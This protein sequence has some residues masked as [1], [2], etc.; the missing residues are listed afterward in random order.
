MNIKN[1][2]GLTDDIEDDLKEFLENQLQEGERRIV[3]K[4]TY[5]ED[6]DCHILH[7]P[8]LIADAKREGLLEE[9]IS[10]EPSTP[11]ADE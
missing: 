1:I 10:Y 7:M 8:D 6:D 11:D 4:I 9:G 3:Q 2:L 5:S